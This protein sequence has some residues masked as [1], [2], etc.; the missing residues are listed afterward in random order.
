[1]KNLKNFLASLVLATGIAFVMPMTANANELATVSDNDVVV[2][3]DNTMEEEEVIETSVDQDNDEVEPE[4]STDEDDNNVLPVDSADE[5]TDDVSE[6]DVEASNDEVND[7]NEE[8]NEDT[9]VSANDVSDNEPII[10][11]VSENDTDTE[12]TVSDNDVTEEAEI[13]VV[14][15]DVAPTPDEE[16]EP[17][18][19]TGEL[20]GPSTRGYTKMSDGS[21]AYCIEADKVHVDADATYEKVETVDG[22]AFD[23]VFAGIYNADEAGKDAT[24]TRQLAQVA[25]WS[26]VDPESNYRATVGLRFGQE[27]LNDFDA[28]LNADTEGFTFIYWGYTPLNTNRRGRQYQKLISG[29]ATKALNGVPEE[30]DEPEVPE[31]PEEPEIPEE[32]ETPEEPEVPEIPETPEQP[33]EPVVP[34]TVEPE[35]P[36]ALTWT[37]VPQTGESGFNFGFDL[38]CVIVLFV[39][40]MVALSTKKKA[41]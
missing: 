8:S 17:E 16:T 24:Y 10:E 34:P 5:E 11:D 6:N 20:V 18:V 40:V 26:I 19:F 25:V 30:P 21:D 22:S 12:G 27:G 3:V 15:G 29:I 35:E 2:T 1:M 39:A 14:A 9:D 38:N 7:V 4:T 37:S 23:S 33:E 28:L 32:P 31:T 36:E 41:N 13:P